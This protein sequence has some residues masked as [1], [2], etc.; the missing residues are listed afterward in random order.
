M[1]AVD[2]SHEYKGDFFDYINAGS[3][4]S[5][6]VVSPLVSGWLKPQSLLDV[7][8]GAGA[9]CKIWKEQG[10]P[11]VT[12]VDGE[13]VKT[14]SLLIPEGD[15][16]RRDL[17][18]PFDLGRKFDLVTSLEVAEHVAEGSARIFVENLVRHG[19]CVMFSAAVP[20]QGG[21]FHVNE[22]PLS[23]WR[24][25]FL[26]HGYRCFDPV[27][28]AIAR[29]ATV[30]PWYRYNILFYVRGETVLRLPEEIRAN[31]VRA[32]SDIRDVSPLGWRARNAIIK[33][34]PAPLVSKLV[35]VKHAV[36]RR[37]RRA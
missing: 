33:S 23:Y 11:E 17:S 27:R 36:S 8:S 19:D 5:A 34:L 25:L 24:A 3:L 29:A 37:V 7:G 20:G 15:F 32:G 28:P 2:S 13:Y 22:K 21:E 18:A 14:E 35:A 26:E 1:N 12:G 6:R 4:A 30:E 16:L 10:I 9:W 31:E